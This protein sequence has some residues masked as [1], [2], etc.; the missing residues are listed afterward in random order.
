MSTY[1]LQGGP[2]LWTIIACS[3]LVIFLIGQRALFVHRSSLRGRDFLGGILNSLRRGNVMEAVALC[4]ETP[5]PVALMARAAILEHQRGG[6]RTGAVMQDVG[7]V[8]IARLEKHLPLLLALAQLAPMLG[9][10][11]T[12]IGMWEMMTTLRVQAPL[13]HGGDLGAGLQR[14]LMTTIAGLA[15][16]AIGYF[17]HAFLVNRVNAVV[18]EMERAYTE[19]LQALAHIPSEMPRA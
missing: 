13:V 16:G 15:T 12:V 4:E 19:I 11:G 8:E 2:V 10:L 7:L 1:L 9:L 6:G 14:A 18:L 5:G 17:G 3:A